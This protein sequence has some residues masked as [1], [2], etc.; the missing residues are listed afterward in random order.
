MKNLADLADLADLVDMCPTMVVLCIPVFLYKNARNAGVRECR[1]D[2][3]GIVA[4]SAKLIPIFI[5]DPLLY[6][7]FRKFSLHRKFSDSLWLLLNYF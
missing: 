5:Q 3:Q 6:S 1:N 2:K 4:K 7:G